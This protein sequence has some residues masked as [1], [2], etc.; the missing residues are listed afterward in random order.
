MIKKLGISKCKN[1]DITVFSKDAF[2]KHVNFQEASYKIK[3]IHN[4]TVFPRV[5]KKFIDEKYINCKCSNRLN[6]LLL[7]EVKIVFSTSNNSVLQVYKTNIIE[8]VSINIPTEISKEDL[9]YKIYNDLL[10]LDIYIERVKVSLESKHSIVMSFFIVTTLDVNELDDFTF[11]ASLKTLEENI[12][13]WN[14]KKKHLI[15][16]TFFIDNHI[17]S[18]DYYNNS[19]YILSIEK[20]NK[21][22]SI[23]DKKIEKIFMY[24]DIGEILSVKKGEYNRLI[25]IAKKNSIV[26]I[27]LYNDGMFDLIDSNIDEENIPIYISK[28]NS[29]LYTKT[30]DETTNIILK[31]IYFNN[32]E[33]N[34]RD[35][36]KVVL[37]LDG[38]VTLL[39]A[40]ND[41]NYI[42]LILNKYRM[43]FYNLHDDIY[44][45]ISCENKFSEIEDIILTKNNN[46][47]IIN[48]KKQGCN[49]IFLV[50]LN[51]NI[52]RNITHNTNNTKISSMFI[53]YSSTFIY[54]S[55][56]SVYGFNIYRININTLEKELLIEL[57]ANNI[58]FI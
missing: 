20:D 10:H 34:C 16:K 17:K 29:L 23:L 31:K 49:D 36:F 9:N 19:G 48:V 56:N 54:L 24:E 5:I 15:Q 35:N 38:K 7:L 25:T 45:E 14:N 2:K 50:Y 12:Y 28:K 42:A 30:I 11:L 27:Y 33:E 46:I 22:Y 32:E 26:S 13:S 43:I 51:K 41:G 37:I 1:K 44:N 3:E 6:L 57:N 53:N 18:V 4:I 8:E 21:I 55:D 58:T 40:S 52:F 47:A 39:T